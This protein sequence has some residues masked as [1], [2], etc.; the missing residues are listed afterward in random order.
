M[1][2]I[3]KTYVTNWNDYVE[4]RDWCIA[5]GSVTDD[6]GNHFSPIDF[7][8]EYEEKDFENINERPIW[9]T[10]TYF[11][12]YLIRNC[13]IELIQKR[14]KEQYGGGWS[15]TA[16][17]E[18]NDN[19]LYYQIKNRTSPY[20]TYKRNG[21]KGNLKFSIIK[22]S[23]FNRFKDDD[24]TWFITVYEPDMNYNSEDNAWYSHYECKEWSSNAAYM[25]GSLSKSKLRRL[26]NR[27]NFPDGTIIRFCGDWHRY[28][29]KEFEVRVTKRNKIL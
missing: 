2:A 26:L 25:R 29:Q 3:D 28:I 5:Q 13:P 22:K 23:Y 11:D 21:T 17:N 15:K 16:F 1:A 19:N 12:I 27:W 24:L 7:L 9:N 20:D 6:Y 4:I 8:I 14:L 18:N 10:P